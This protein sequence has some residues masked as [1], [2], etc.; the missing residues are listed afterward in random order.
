MVLMQSSTKPTINLVILGVIDIETTLEKMA[1]E[2][3]PVL[4]Q[5]AAQFKQE[6]ASNLKD[7]ISTRMR[8]F[9]EME[10]L[11]ALLDPEMK[12]ISEVRN[13]VPG[14]NA[15]DFLFD[16]ILTHAPV[17][18]TDDPDDSDDVTVTSEPPPKQQRSSLIAKYANLETPSESLSNEVN[19]YL[20]RQVTLCDSSDGTE[21]RDRVLQWWFEN[22]KSYPSLARLAQIVLSIPATSAEPE[23]RFSSAGNALREKRCS[24]NPTTMSKTLFIHDNKDIIPKL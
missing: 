14:A 24:M 13:E 4:R 8:P 23:R 22:A 20:A 2:A 10:I 6:L 18:G 9:S 5:S 1:H 12:S 15:A 7:S 17:F 21:A 16:A 11:G 19:R 3:A